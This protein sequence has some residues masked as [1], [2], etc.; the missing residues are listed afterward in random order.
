MVRDSEV[1]YLK[2][3]GSPMNG[4]K[5][6]WRVEGHHLSL[7]FALENGKI[8]AATPVFFGANPAELRQGPL[9]AAPSRR[10]TIVVW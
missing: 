4:G 9:P 5:W 8:V 6:G 3:F 7:N 2:I 1:Y 10:I